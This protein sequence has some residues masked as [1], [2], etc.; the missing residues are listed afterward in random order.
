MITPFQI[1]H[2]LQKLKL[3]ILK[4]CHDS[5]CNAHT[6]LN[7]GDVVL[8]LSGFLRCDPFRFI[9]VLSALCV[10]V[11]GVCQE[12]TTPRAQRLPT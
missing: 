1:H 5:F 7:T 6:Q 9:L 3:I 2:K 10:W 4:S 12:H 8:L 11:T